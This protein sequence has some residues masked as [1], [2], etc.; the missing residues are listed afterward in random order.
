MSGVTE[1]QKNWGERDIPDQTGKVVFITGANI[2]LGFEAARMLSARGARVLMACRDERRASDAIAA[3]KRKH[4][5]AQLDFVP[6]D[7]ADLDQVAGAAARI[8]SLGVATIDV[9]LNNAGVMMPPKRQQTKQGF[10]LQFG[11]NHL[12]HFLL[13]KTLFPAL[14]SEARIVTVASIADRRGDINWP[15]LQWTQSYNPSAA[16]GQSKTANL[17]FTLA[18][19]RRLHDATSNKRALAAHPGV[20]MTNLATSSTIGPW[21]WLI[22]PLLAVGVGPK[23]QSPAMGALPEVYAAVGAVDPGAYYGPANRTHGS[24]TRAE[25][26]QAAHSS[27][28][29]AAERLWAISEQLTGGPFAVS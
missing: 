6:L 12:A 14:S 8:Q 7:L 3:I 16:Y 23:V 28:S 1:V 4:K 18:L 25:A 24:P 15:D 27:D 13:T 11:V 5:N 29:E 9:L 2:G 17:L 20:A 26:H 10:E 22:K 21:L 19:S